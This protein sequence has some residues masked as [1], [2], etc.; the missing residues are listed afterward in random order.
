MISTAVFDIETSDLQAD[1]GI[2][3]CACVKSS[4]DG[5]MHVIRTDETNK[6]WEKG[7]R[8][9]D[10]GTVRAL[11]D[12]LSEH[13]IL[14]A[15]NGGRFDIPFLRTRMLR[16][17]MKRLPPVKHV[18]PLSIAWRHLR[19]NKNGL[20]ALADHMGIKEKKTPLEWAEWMKAILDGDRRAMN[21]IVAHCK[22]DVIVLE[23]VLD[24][25]KSYCKLFDDRGSA[26]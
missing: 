2:I 22:A 6:D 16:W 15:H 24:N 13:D 18:D 17:G 4:V 5:K 21:K 8:A 19:L 25:V 26:L 11:A 14:A 12:I 10:R 7:K 3:L 23:K 20:G 9:N 1:R